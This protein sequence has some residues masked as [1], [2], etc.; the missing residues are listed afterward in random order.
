MTNNVTEAGKNLITRFHIPKSTGISPLTFRLP[1]K[2]GRGSVTVLCGENG[3]GKSFILRALKGVATGKQSASSF[4]SFKLETTG[5]GPVRIV[6]PHHHKERMTALGILGEVQAGKSLRPGDE[7]L[8]LKIGLFSEIFSEVLQAFDI[9][10]SFDKAK[11]L[12][13]PSYR[14]EVYRLIPE[15]DEMLARL[16]VDHHEFISVF[17]R[18]TN[19]AL[20]CRK[21]EKGIELVLVWGNG[22]VAPYPDWSDGQKSLFTILTEVSVEKPDV[23]AYDEIENFFHPKYITDVLEFLKSNIPQTILASHHPHL[24]FGRAVDD[25]YF[26]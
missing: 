19:A 12:T 11:W 17:L 8:S 18:T 22:V 14:A 24:I 5:D 6:R 15:D 26:I 2:S 1:D 13:D 23:C 25:V 16:E 10:R 9:E 20:G 3:T 7:Y 4:P 21:H